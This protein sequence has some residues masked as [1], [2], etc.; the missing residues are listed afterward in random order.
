MPIAVLMA[1]S[2][3]AS[4]SRNTWGGFSLQWYAELFRDPT[5]MRALYV[6]IAIA[7]LASVI[8]TAAGTIAAVGLHSMG[9]ISKRVW[10]SVNNLPVFNPDIVTGVSLMVLFISAFRI[11]R[12]GSLGFGTLLIAHVLFGIPYV[13]LAVLPKLRQMDQNLYEAA[14]DLGATPRQAFLKV[15]LPEI[16]PG[17]ITG[18]MLSF[19]MSIDDFV[20][21]FFTTGSG[22][23]NISTIV[24]SMARRGINPMI[25]ALSTLMFV[26]VIILLF[27]IN[28]RDVELR[29]GAVS[30]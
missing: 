20:I 12:F 10:L 18:A 30:R 11:F 28:K 5:I 16:S 29:K 6:T 17:I 9:K 22:V 26:V 2:F 15:I 3:N 7:V 23:N 24:Y 8:S 14:L 27:I 1:L 21:S 25:N 19:T 4:R 13:I